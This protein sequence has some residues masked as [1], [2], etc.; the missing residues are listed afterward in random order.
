[1]AAATQDIHQA[2]EH[3]KVVILVGHSTGTCITQVTMEEARW[4]TDS[5]NG[6]S[7]IAC[8]HLND[9]ISRFDLAFK[10]LASWSNFETLDAW[11]DLW[12]RPSINHCNPI[13]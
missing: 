13:G 6:T 4:I 5:S 3:A 2:V 8:A 7:S 10:M 1:M 12:D 11:V 9:Y